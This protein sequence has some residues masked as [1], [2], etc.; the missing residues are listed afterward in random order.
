MGVPY[1]YTALAFLFPGYRIRA[2]SGSPVRHRGADH[3]YSPNLNHSGGPLRSREFGGGR[4]PSRYRDSSPPYGRGRGGGR[5]FS[6][7]LDGP[8]F[9]PG[10]FRGEGMSRNNPNVQPREG[11]WYCPDPA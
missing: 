7:A 8:G 3:R 4:D 5:P 2:V 10:P 1:I 11:D 9:G 6:R